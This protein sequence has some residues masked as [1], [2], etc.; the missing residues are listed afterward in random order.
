[1]GEKLQSGVDTTF[2]DKD[3]KAICVHA[4]VKDGNGRVYFINSHCQAV[5]EGEE[6]PA[7]E[8]SRLIESTEVSVMSA[9]EVLES[10][11]VVEKPRRGGRRHREPAAAPDEK[12]PDEVAP[13]SSDAAKPQGPLFPASMQLVLSA[14]PDNVLA[15]ELRRRGYTLCAV[16]PALIT[17]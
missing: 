12:K 7:V 16:K 13:E 5:P 14:I 9:K 11:K 17:I 2:K 6:A 3:G 8:L 10:G 1:M 15:E 4:Y